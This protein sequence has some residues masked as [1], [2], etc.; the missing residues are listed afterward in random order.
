MK[1]RD[2]R[3]FLNRITTVNVRNIDPGEAS[4]GFILTAQGKIRSAFKIAC[5]EE[6]R[7]VFEI[8]NG[9]EE[10]WKSEFLS[11]LDQFTFAEKYELHEE[12][13][14]LNAWVFEGKTS[15]PTGAKASERFESRD[16]LF[17]FHST[18]SSHDASS[19]S[20]GFS[21]TSAWGPRSSVEAWI[22]AQNASPFLENELEFFRIRAL[23][24]RV[25]HELVFEANPLEI[26]M[27]DGIADNKGCYPGQEVIEK[28][29]SLG[30]PA[31]R[32]ALLVGSMNGA[33]APKT[34]AQVFSSEGSVLGTLSSAAESKGEIAGLVL[35]RKNALEV[36]KAV[37]VG[38]SPETAVEMKIERISQYE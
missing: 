33:E 7:F 36:G 2:A 10:R 17:L 28:I 11:V 21:W 30:S 8:Q 18:S 15:N 32:L 24:A 9:N 5:I 6:D 23:R 1:G 35:L 4:L 29:I 34:G 26:G 19:G 37:K 13:E 27:R 14:W 12:K 20:D 3:D 16:D 38:T 31:K 25:D 22:S